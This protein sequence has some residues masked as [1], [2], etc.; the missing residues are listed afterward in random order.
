[1][2]RIDSE[3]A[4]PNFAERFRREAIVPTGTADF[5]VTIPVWT[6][7]VQVRVT[8]FD[9]NAGTLPN[10]DAVSPRE[11]WTGVKIGEDKLL[12]IEARNYTITNLQSLLEPFGVT[13]SAALAINNLG[14]V[15]VDGAIG[16]TE[17][18]HLFLID[19][20]RVVTDL[21]PLIPGFYLYG[22]HMNDSRVIAGTRLSEDGEVE[23]GFIY[24]HGQSPSLIDLG[25][26]HIPYDIN[27][28]GD[29]VGEKNEL[30]LGFVRYR[31]GTTVELGDEVTGIN[32]LGDAVGVHDAGAFVYLD[33]DGDGD[34]EEIDI[35]K[36]PVQAASI[37]M[38]RPKIN[39]SGLIVGVY[40]TFLGTAPYFL[41]E[42]RWTTFPSFGGF[43][44]SGFNESGVAIG[45]NVARDL[46]GRVT[47]SAWI[48]TTSGSTDIK[49]LNPPNSPFSKLDDVS[50][51]ND[52]G[53]MVGTGPLTYPYSGAYVLKKVL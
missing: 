16:H 36:P 37:F 33:D 4:G 24:R 11:N 52:R 13:G 42:G 39:D 51:I 30:G 46:F 9:R 21:T 18:T 7:N 43:N 53:D 1:L 20:D 27:N 29:V 6:G 3:Q 15:V 19:R 2:L 14:D 41:E 26:D 50:D 31:D 22:L 23:E 47:F 17:K 10:L 49:N 44:V 38:G 8:G 34:R 40:R 48:L 25:V 32:N 35:G 5:V 45:N 28:A 12:K